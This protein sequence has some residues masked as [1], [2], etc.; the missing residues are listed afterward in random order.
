MDNGH[1]VKDRGLVLSTHSFKESEVILLSNIL[2][3]KFKLKTTIHK[4]L[5]FINVS[6][7]EIN[8][9]YYSIYINKV[10]VP[11]LINI[12]KPY[13]IPTMLYKLGIK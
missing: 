12:V 4:R 2:N 9:I 10:S 8:S 3:N 13:I 11:K 7:N 5:K 6:S 1:Y